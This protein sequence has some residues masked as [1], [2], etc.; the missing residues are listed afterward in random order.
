MQQC[1]EPELE[2]SLNLVL[3]LLQCHQITALCSVEAVDQSEIVVQLQHAVR[4]RVVWPRNGPVTIW[5]ARGRKSRPIP[6]LERA[7]AQGLIYMPITMAEIY[8]SLQDKERAFHWLEDA[9]QHYRQ[10]YSESADGGMSTLKADWWLD[11]LHGDPRY[12][13]LLHRVGII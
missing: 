1:I 4:I 10:G 3:W 5:I 13:S 8:C 7:Q 2:G 11:S 9:Y 12:Q 6:H